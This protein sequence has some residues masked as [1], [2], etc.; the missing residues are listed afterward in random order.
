MSIK[1]DARLIQ[2][3][4][5][6]S[7]TCALYD[8]RRIRAERGEE[9]QARRKTEPDKRLSQIVLEMWHEDYELEE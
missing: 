1:S 4:T 9:I 5:G 3:T 2:R 7:Y 8:A 6:V